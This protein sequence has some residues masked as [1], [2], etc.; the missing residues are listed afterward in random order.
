MST[1]SAINSA[2]AYGLRFALCAVVAER[3]AEAAALLPFLFADLVELLVFGR[4]EVGMLDAE[5]II[6]YSIRNGV[7]IISFDLKRIPGLGPIDV[8]PQNGWMVARDQFVNLRKSVF[9]VFLALRLDGLIVRDGPDWP[10]HKG[11]VIAAGV[12]EAH[13]HAVIRHS[14]GEFADEIA[15]GVL[16]VGRQRR[17][18]GCARPESKSFVVLAGQHNIARTRFAKN[19]SHLV[20]IPLFAFAIESLREVVVVVVGTVMLAMVRLRW[21]AIDPHY[22]VIPLGIG[23]EL[24]VVRRCEVVLRM[25]KWRPSRDRIQ[26]PMNEDAELCPG[27]PFRQRMPVQRLQRGLIFHGSL[28][29]AEPTNHH[30]CG[31]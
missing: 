9:T 25:R 21:R 22:V 19:G 23:I 15:R 7:V 24:D 12:V 8:V 26:A 11:P 14:L 5:A 20:G 3:T 18:R 27:V 4:L 31:Y 2:G 6:D 17:I 28:R 16:A 30:Q 10:W 29:G 1:R 13:A